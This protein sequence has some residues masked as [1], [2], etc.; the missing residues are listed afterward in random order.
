MRH[1]QNHL[2]VELMAL[3]PAAR[4]AF[5]DRVRIDEDAVEVEEES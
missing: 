5:D 2:G 1:S 3:S 4:R